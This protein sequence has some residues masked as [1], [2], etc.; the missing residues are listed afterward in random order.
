LN[1]EIRVTPASD[2]HFERLRLDRELA[3]KDYESLR[4]KL[5]EAQEAQAIE[6]RMIGT[7]L[8]TL[9]PAF[10]PD[11]P[12]TSRTETALYGLGFGLLVGIG[13]WLFQALRRSATGLL[14]PE[15]SH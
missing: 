5:K 10:L 7:N 14:T 1:R 9:D 6:N 3:R 2:P 11:G 4:Q 13:A 12:D 15:M 8:Q